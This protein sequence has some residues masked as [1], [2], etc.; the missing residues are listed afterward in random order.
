M[1]NP[2]NDPV[3]EAINRFFNAFPAGPLGIEEVGIS[4]CNRRIVA[5]DVKASIDS[6]PF[7]RA[8]VEGYLVNVSDTSQAGDNKPVTLTVS[9]TIEPGKAYTED[10]TAMTCMELST[11]G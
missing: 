3:V 6:P 5:V 4:E 11:G 1:N 7:S 8:L 10:L 2:Q 9:G